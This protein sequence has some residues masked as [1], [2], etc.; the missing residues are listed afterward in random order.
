MS[1]GKKSQT[2]QSLS[3]KANAAFLKASEDVVE[4]AKQARTDVIIW[5][6]NR[7]VRL[8]AEE[9]AGLI[10]ERRRNGSHRKSG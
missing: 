4:K 2:D 1:I 7:I 8:P 10:E 6:D 9:A 3:D 5:R